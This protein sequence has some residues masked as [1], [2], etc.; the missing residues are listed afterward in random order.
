MSSNRWNI[1]QADVVGQRW[2]KGKEGN[3]EEMQEE[4]IE[5]RAGTRGRENKVE[6][7]NRR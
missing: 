5:S 6:I 1:V 2:E 3:F 4:L 7:R